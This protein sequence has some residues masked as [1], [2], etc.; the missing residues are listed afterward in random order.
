MEVGSKLHPRSFYEEVAS[1]VKIITKLL[2]FSAPGVEAMQE[3]KPSVRVSQRAVNELKDFWIF[4]KYSLV[5][6]T[7]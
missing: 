2:R 3:Q 7:K 6:N 5:M 4:N 1:E